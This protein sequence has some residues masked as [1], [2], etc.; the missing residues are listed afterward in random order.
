MQSYWQYVVLLGAVVIVCAFVWPRKQQQSPAIPT[1]TMQNMEIALEQF[2][3]NMEKDN[4]DL[5]ELVTKAQL[6]AK[7]DADHKE[8]RIVAL[9]HKCELLTEQL[10]RALERTV[11]PASQLPES[12]PLT[13]VNTVAAARDAVVEVGTGL[14]EKVQTNSILSRYSELFELY[15][16]GKS[17]EAISKK[18]GL[19]KGEVLLII[20][21][22][23]QEEANHA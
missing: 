22:S 19:N 1:Q 23:K 12:T 15:E 18:L 3:E 4:Q 6:D 10:Q 20:Q 5:V 8:Q 17:I 2:M 14:T 21:L 7:V 9:E 13:K 11:I 16:Q